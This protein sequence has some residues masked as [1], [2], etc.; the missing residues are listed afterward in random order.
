MDIKEAQRIMLGEMHRYGLTQSGWTFKW[1]R[2]KS[3]NGRCDYNRRVISL[4]FPLTSQR[5]EAAVRNTIIHE[6]AHALTPGA[7]HGEVW[8]RKFIQM[9]GDGKRRSGDRVS[10]EYKWTALCAVSGKTLG[11]THRKSAK[12]GRSICRCHRVAPI[13]QENN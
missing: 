11:K 1:D 12:M 7:G 6:I 5:E 2:A 3:R 10:I 4:S 8:R 13:W 9:G